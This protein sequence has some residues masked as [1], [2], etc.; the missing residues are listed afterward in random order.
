VTDESQ[1]KSEM[2]EKPTLSV[3]IITFNEEDHIQDCL[4]SVMDMA[5]EIIIL[6]SFSTDATESICRRNQKVKFSQHPFDGHIQQ[7]NRA[8]EKCSCEWILSIDADERVSP[9]LRNSIEDFLTKYQ[10]DVAGA[11]F[12]RLAYHMHRYIRHGGW[13]PNS[14]YRLVKRGMAYWG[15]ENPHDKLVL[16]GK[17]VK[18]NGDLIHF[19]ERDLSDQ[20]NTINNFSSIAALMRFNKGKK[21]HLWR[22]L[23]KP[24]SKFLETYVFK[25]GF[26]DRTQG[27]IIAVSSSYASFLKEAKQYEMDVLGSDKPSNLS[28]L[29]Q[30][31]RA[32]EKSEKPS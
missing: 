30:K 11:K 1:G 23:L 32:H 18:I 5:D 15:G 29:Y 13:Y 12:P 26:L 4:N 21:Y 27:F 16:K 7:K 25:L 19:T 10:N 9:E 8:L 6:D 31:T 3:A 17:G 2:N 14:R 22:L 28:H 24:I 20:V